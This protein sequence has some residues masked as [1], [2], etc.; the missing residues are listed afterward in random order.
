ML[1]K[2][3]FLPSSIESFSCPGRAVDGDRKTHPLGSAVEKFIV[4]TVAMTTDPL[5]LAG[6]EWSDDGATMANRFVRHG[7]RN[8]RR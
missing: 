4:E 7:L 1:A 6:I 3:T 8:L 2:P 5:A